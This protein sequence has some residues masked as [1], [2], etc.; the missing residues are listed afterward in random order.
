MDFE[1]VAGEGYEDFVE[2]IGDVLADGC[3]EPAQLTGGNSALVAGGGGFLTHF[4][5]QLK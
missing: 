2:A 5:E 3:N 1:G 4:G